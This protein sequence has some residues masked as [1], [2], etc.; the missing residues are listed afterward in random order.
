MSNLS[1]TLAVSP[2]RRNLQGSSLFYP[3]SIVK[4]AMFSENRKNFVKGNIEIWAVLLGV[5][6]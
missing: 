4:G 6:G 3:L 1:I 2:V 5:M